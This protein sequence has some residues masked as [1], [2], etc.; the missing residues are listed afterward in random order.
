MTSIL[1]PL[2]TFPYVARILMPEGLGE[3]N[4]LN[5]I[6]GYIV[7][8]TSL[9]IPMYA[10]KE[11]GRVQDNIKERN[12]IA[13]EIIYLSLSLCIFGYII[14]FL[15]I[16]YVPKIATQYRL[17]LILSLTI[18]F[19][20]IGVN[21]FFQ[22][23]ENFKYITIRA[24]IFR[25]LSAICLF[26]F[27]KSPED[28]LTYGCIVVGS[29]VGNNFINF[30][31]LRNFIPLK[32]FKIK[33]LH[34][35]RHFRPIIQVFTL[36]LIIS[37]YV[38]LNTIML[39]F[40]ADDKQVGYFVAG[41]KITHV[42]IT[43]IGSISIV[44]I[45]RC[46]NLLKNGDTGSF[47][48]LIN[49]SLNLNLL[50][51][52]PIMVGL[53]VLATPLTYV[54]CGREY[55]QAI[56][57]LYWNIPVIYL[58]NITTL[59]GLQILYPLGKLNY[60]IISVLFGA[61]VNIVFNLIFIPKYGAQGA[62]ISTTITEI[63]VYFIQIILGRKYYPFSLSKLWNIKYILAT[64]IACG[65]VY[66]ANIRLSSDYTR[67]ILGIVIGSVSYFSILYYLRDSTTHEIINIFTKKQINLK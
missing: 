39:G 34:I 35:W 1:F 11:I 21:W 19:N 22:G 14:V 36:N 24:I 50:L 30:F 55:G 16:E 52:I 26:L 18:F 59:T 27:V 32:Y 12:T 58:I 48:K 46:S 51:S 23:T 44:M 61:V 13:A 60:V 28:I 33:N 40:M 3:F 63:T 9:G 57:I 56:P 10:V 65:L 42:A 8:I 37:L 53:Y 31:H 38:Q 62:A 29:T 54:F 47:S 2:V 43:L 5:G 6:I 20:C 64:L 25:S 4:F 41:T 67:I 49:K 45:P 17:F 15:L 7:L 66:L